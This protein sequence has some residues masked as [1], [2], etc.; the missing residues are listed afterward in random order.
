MI[1]RIITLAPEDDVAGIK[2]HIEWANA[3]RVLLVGSDIFRR[4]INLARLQ[5]LQQ[6]TGTQIAVVSPS[7]QVRYMAKTVGLAAFRTVAEA[8]HKKWL[9]KISSDVEPIVRLEPPR[10]FAPNSLQHFFPQTHV[11]THGVRGLAMLLVV[12]A[13]AVSALAIVPTAKVNLTAA[14]QLISRIVPV[15]LDVRADKVDLDQLIVPAQRV[16]VVVED[17]LSTPTTGSKDVQRFR[18][19]GR[20]VFLNNTATEFEVRKGT[21]VRTTNNSR[22]VRFATVKAVKLPPSGQATA[23]I[24]AI[25]P[26]PLGNVGPNAINQV[27]GITGLSVRVSNPI[28]TGGGGG[29]SVRSVTQDDYARARLELRAKLFDTALAQMRQQRQIADNGLFIVPDSFFIA[30]VQDETYDHFVGEQSEALNLSMRIQVSAIA[31]SPE[32]LNAVAGNALQT[33]VPEGFSLLAA[34]ADRGEVV[35]E[36]TGARTVYYINARG[37]AGAQIDR[38]LVRRLVRGKNIAEA[39]RILQSNFSL[40]QAPQITVQPVWIARLLNRVPFVSVR[41]EPEVTRE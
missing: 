39:Q 24:E 27:E 4:E 33:S 2:D 34:V 6:Q 15:T 8:Q 12:G 38:N 26:G 18:S 25:E 28:G 29:D 7:I 40:S 11:I 32:D 21:V 5:R 20:V 14:R 35:E 31:V 23:D 19:G 1:G 9:T 22:P 16:D 13:I 30:D 37:M 41:I 36:G 3:D 17:A 10:R